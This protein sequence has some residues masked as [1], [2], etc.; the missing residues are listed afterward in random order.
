MDEILELDGELNNNLNKNIEEKENLQNNYLKTNNSFGDLTLSDIGNKEMCTIPLSQR[1]SNKITENDELNKNYIINII[2]KRASLGSIRL[3]DYNDIFSA[4]KKVKIRKEDLNNIPIP[5]FS[6]IFCSNEYISFNHYINE[7]LSNKYKILTSIYDLQ[8]LNK[9]LSNKYLIDNGDKND[10][11]ENLIIK[12]TEYLLKYYEY[13][14]EEY[15]KIINLRGDEK[16]LFEIEQ[17]KYIEY[18]NTKLNNL[19]LK[20]NKK[21]FFKIQSITKKINNYYSFNN[22]LNMNSYM[23]NS[24]DGILNFNNKKNPQN[25]NINHTMTNLSVSNFNSVSLINYLDYNNPREKENKFKLDDIIEQIEKNSNIESFRFDMS[26]NIKKED[27]EWDTEYYNIWNPNIEPLFNNYIPITSKKIC[28]NINKTFIK[29]QKKN[30]KFYKI[31]K[32]NNSN[33][34]TRVKSK[35]KGNIKSNK[36]YQKNNNNIWKNRTKGK[37]QDRNKLFIKHKITHLITH[38]SKNNK[39]NILI[40]LNNN[41]PKLKNTKN[42]NKINTFTK[43]DNSQKY[44]NKISTNISLNLKK[45]INM[46]PINLFNSSNKIIKLRN[47][48]ILKNQIPLN[49]SV[50]DKSTNMSKAKS[51]INFSIN[52]SEKIINENKK[53]ENNNKKKENKFLS[54][55]S[56]VSSK[57]LVNKNNK[58]EKEIMNRLPKFKKINEIKRDQKHVTNKISRN[59]TFQNLNKIKEKSL[60]INISKNCLCE[61]KVGLSNEK[62]KCKSKNMANIKNKVIINLKKQ[63]NKNG[64]NNIQLKNK[65]GINKSNVNKYNYYD[66]NKILFD[67]KIFDKKNVATKKRIFNK[68]NILIEH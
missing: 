40:N 67:I 6:C 7:I 29:I 37:S 19:K 51:K 66:S 39:R 35:G 21:I 56:S 60:I 14:C 62:N 12:N 38:S 47:F 22:N 15:K 61:I 13:N 34:L 31:F 64:Y 8:E 25:N 46:N 23:N 16:T 17:K 28:N 55:N 32:E 43:K 42:K 41:T 2:E 58:K 33:K 4:K 3:E 24:I 20:K 27:I 53:E 48:Q 26:R 57:K 63:V 11:L 59:N 10:K 52:N 36:S 9:L 65:S 68:K 5:L 1:T 44:L 18:I 50:L 30:H 49:I 54:Q 45:N